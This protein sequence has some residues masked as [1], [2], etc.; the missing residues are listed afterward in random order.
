MSLN[1][2]ALRIARAAYEISKLGISSLLIF[3]GFLSANLAVI[4]F[5]PIPMLDGGHMVFLGYE[6]ITAQKTQ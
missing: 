1:C 3:L 4:N 2:T 6:A 5:L